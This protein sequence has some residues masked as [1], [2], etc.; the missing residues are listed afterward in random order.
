MTLQCDIVVSSSQIR[1]ETQAAQESSPHTTQACTLGAG[2]VVKTG[3]GGASPPRTPATVKTVSQ[4][5]EDHAPHQ[6]ST[7][8]Q[9]PHTDKLVTKPNVKFCFHD[10]VNNAVL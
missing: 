8:G 4:G 3:P 1:M 7:R 2:L 9:M 5:S 10:S 6:H